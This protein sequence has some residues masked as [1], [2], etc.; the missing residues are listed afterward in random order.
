[1][2]GEVSTAMSDI[3]QSV[4]IG[5]ASLTISC[6]QEKGCG[7]LLKSNSFTDALLL[8][9]VQLGQRATMRRK[10]YNYFSP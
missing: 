6:W 4:E 7:V 5:P 8:Y 3:E 2:D 10:R 1:M 9:A